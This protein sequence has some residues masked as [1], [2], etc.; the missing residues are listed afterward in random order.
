MISSFYCYSLTQLALD[1][2]L[3]V[4]ELNAYTLSFTFF[5]TPK[6]PNFELYFSGFGDNN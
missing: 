4:K 2:F 6:R 3:K 5:V 1:S